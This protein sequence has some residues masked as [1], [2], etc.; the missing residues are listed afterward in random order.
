[1]GNITIQMR[2]DKPITTANFVSLTQHGLYDGTIFHRVIA[3]FM[4]QGGQLSSSASNIHDEIGNDNANYN[5]TIA[6]ANTGAA[7]SGTSQF[8]I[9]VANNGNNEIDPQG[10]KFDTKYTVFGQVIGGMDIVMKISNV[11]VTTNPNTQESQPS[12]PIQTITLQ[13]A[14]IVTH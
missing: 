8:F 4:I 13:H 10:T 9:N 2:D 12:Q 5:G 1:M 14:F 3:G 6:M 11:A 7:N